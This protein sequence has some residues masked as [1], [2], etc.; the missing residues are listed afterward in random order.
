MSSEML[1][2]L[3]FLQEPTFCEIYR[4]FIMG[5]NSTYVADLRKTK[6]ETA[7]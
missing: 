5:R 6:E 4:Q 7:E 2:H 1:W 3:H